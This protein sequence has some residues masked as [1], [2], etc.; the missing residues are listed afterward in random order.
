MIDIKM[1]PDWGGTYVVLLLAISEARGA[2]RFPS[3]RNPN[4][5]YHTA[6][7]AQEVY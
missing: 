1:M 7:K 6:R 3:V 5:K 4:S 2:F